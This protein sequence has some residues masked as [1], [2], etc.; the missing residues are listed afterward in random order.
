MKLK[1]GP[2]A[3]SRHAP[4]ED[5]PWIVGNEAQFQEFKNTAHRTSLFRD[6]PSTKEQAKRSMKTLDQIIRGEKGPMGARWA[7]KNKP[8]MRMVDR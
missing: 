8:P 7:L 5:H 1:R 2:G 3:G 6:I 4:N